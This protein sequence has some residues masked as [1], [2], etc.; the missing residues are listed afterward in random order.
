MN[1]KVSCSVIDI[2]SI[3]DKIQCFHIIFLNKDISITIKDNAMKFCKA[4]LHTHS[5]GSVSQVFYLGLSF[6]FM[7]FRK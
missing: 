2:R 5:K 7:L 1:S 3:K 6:Y 4:L